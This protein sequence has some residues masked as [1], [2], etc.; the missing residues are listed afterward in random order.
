MACQIDPHCSACGVCIAICPVWAIT[1]T[2]AGVFIEAALCTECA[3]YA[4]EPVCA[5]GCPCAA[6]ST[7]DVPVLSSSPN[8]F[9]R[10]HGSLTRNQNAHNHLGN[11]HNHLG[12][13]GGV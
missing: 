4:D 8:R 10:N 11:A 6:I 2:T 13:V 3:G 12:N 1:E 9:S 5:D 7:A